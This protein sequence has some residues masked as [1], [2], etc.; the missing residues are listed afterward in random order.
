M[1]LDAVREG[2]SRGASIT[3]LPELAITGYPPEDLLLREQFVVAARHHL[4]EI[5]ASVT[6]GIAIV[7]FPELDG[8]L[9]NAAAVLAAIACRYRSAARSRSPSASS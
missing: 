5:A 6:E 9:F 8:D 2:Q 4:D 7:G 1:A 3:V